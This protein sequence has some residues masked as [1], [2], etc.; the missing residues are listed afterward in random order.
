MYCSATDVRGI[1]TQMAEGAKTPD[2]PTYVS[3]EMLLDM[4]ERASRIF[5]LACGARP[6]YF[7]P[8][9]YATWESAHVYIVGEIVT[10]TTRNSHKYRV[11]T[12]GTS[13]S[14]EPTFPTSSAGTVTSGNAVF[15]E[16]GADVTTSDRTFYGDGTNYLRLDPYVAG[17]LDPTIIFPTGYTAPGFVERDGYLVQSSNGILP[18]FA[19]SI[20]SQGWSRGVPVTV[21]ALWGYDSTPADVK[22]AIIELVINLWRET[23]PA[24][25]K[26]TNLEGQPLREK[27]PPRVSEIVRLYRTKVAEVMFA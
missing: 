25:L 22:S 12:A 8:A 5:D 6:E 10:P 17:S 13:G 16:N 3:N 18:P 4:I 1:A 15:T 9:L 11:T 20:F 23:D 7:E 14:S 24:S 27:L 26:L 21:T 2:S 19:P